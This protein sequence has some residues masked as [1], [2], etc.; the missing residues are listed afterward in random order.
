[1]V[2]LSAECPIGVRVLVYK[3]FEHLTFEFIIKLHLVKNTSIFYIKRPKETK[4]VKWSL[5]YFGIYIIRQLVTPVSTINS[6]DCT[7]LFWKVCTEE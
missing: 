2:F 1:M 3:K 7:Y 4:L 5:I 6:S